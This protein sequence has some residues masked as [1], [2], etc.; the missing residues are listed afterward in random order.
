MNQIASKKF[1]LILIFKFFPPKGDLFP[2]IDA[3]AMYKVKFFTTEYFVANNQTNFFYPYVEIVFKVEAG[4]HYHIPL[5][6][7]PF[8]YSTYRGS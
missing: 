2:K 1:S 3:P 6:L 5:L 8:G 7:S 4:Q